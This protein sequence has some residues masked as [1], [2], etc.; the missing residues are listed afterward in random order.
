MYVT[1]ILYT[2]LNLR[3]QFRNP[4]FVDREHTFST[5]SFKRMEEDRAN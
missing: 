1:N 5:G 4:D 3:V 2:H